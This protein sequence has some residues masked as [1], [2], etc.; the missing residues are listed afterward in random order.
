V[1]TLWPRARGAGVSRETFDSVA[2]GLE[3]DA[4]L[5]GLRA[6]QSEFSRPLSAYLAE[7]A[8]AGRASRAQAQL[9]AMRAHC[10]ASKATT[11]STG[12]SCSLS[13]A[14]RRI[15][16]AIWVNRDVLRSL[17]TLAY[18]HPDN[19][20]YAEEFIAGLAM[21]EKGTLSARG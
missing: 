12:R 11:A 18:A 5:M 15:S 6:R 1:E 14:W 19:P 3:A 10:R 7:A 17:A 8:S 9:R 4:S 20:V 13:G 16:V 2:R 21:I